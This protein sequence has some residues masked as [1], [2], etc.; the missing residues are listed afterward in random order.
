MVEDNFW[1]GFAL[2]NLDNVDGTATLYF[3]ESDG[4][5]GYMVVSVS[6]GAMFVRTLS[7]MFVAPVGGQ[8]VEPLT[9]TSGDGML[10]DERLFIVA[11]T[12]FQM[13]WV[14]LYGKKPGRKR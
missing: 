10:G 9:Q 6:E 2:V 13:R 1:D 8:V 12:D 11:C 3:N 7:D 4:D 14:R 5:K